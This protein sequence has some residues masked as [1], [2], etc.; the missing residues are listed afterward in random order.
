[1]V[2]YNDGIGIIHSS[3]TANQQLRLVVLVHVRSVR[4][5]EFAELHV[6]VNDVR[7]TLRWVEASNLYKIFAIRP[8]ELVH[9]FFGAKVAEFGHVIV[10]VPGMKLFV[11]TVQPSE[12]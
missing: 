5:E 7:N 3:M 4:L 1:L 10:R 9:L 2:I 11:E 12:G 8:F 6:R